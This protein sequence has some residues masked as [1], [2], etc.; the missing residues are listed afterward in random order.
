MAIKQRNVAGLPAQQKVLFDRADT[1]MKQRNYAY[2][3]EMLRTLLRAEHA[4][5]VVCIG[6]RIRAGV[7]QLRQQRE[8][9]CDARPQA[10]QNGF[11]A[12]CGRRVSTQP[13]V[14]RQKDHRV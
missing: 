5:G 11:Y 9:G 4:R 8:I 12:I 10:D 3:L 14:L 7:D 1:A 13:L 6:S 2:A